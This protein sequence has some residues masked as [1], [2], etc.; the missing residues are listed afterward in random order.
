MRAACSALSGWT[1]RRL[2]VLPDRIDGEGTLSCSRESSSTSR[3]MHFSLVLIILASCVLPGCAGAASRAPRPLDI[4]LDGT[5]ILGCIPS[6][7]GE[8]IAVA[9]AGVSAIGLEANGSLVSWS[10][11]AAGGNAKLSLAPGECL[12]YGTV[13]EGYDSD[14]SESALLDETPYAYTLRSPEWGKYGTRLHTGVFCIRRSGNGID[15]AEVPRGPRAPT[16]ET[17][18]RLLDAKER[19]LIPRP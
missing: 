5:T 6:D 16:A 7:E 15:L 11:S 17:C 9:D 4:R 2:I 10:I 18:V 13:P 14:A 1:E 12:A 3:M 19:A 8:D